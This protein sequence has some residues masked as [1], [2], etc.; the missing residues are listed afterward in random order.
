MTTPTPVP[1]IKIPSSGPKIN[2]YIKNLT[3]YTNNELKNKKKSIEDVLEIENRLNKF[4]DTY[5]K[6]YIEY[7]KIIAIFIFTIICIWLC[8]MINN[9]GILPEGFI[10]FIIIIISTIGIS[11]IYYV[12][13]NISIHNLLIYDQIDYE[14][15]ELKDEKSLETPQPTAST[16]KS[17]PTKCPVVCPANYVYNG[18]FCEYSLLQNLK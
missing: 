14:S 7:I 5:N 1:T 9:Q 11:W 16:Q 15:P 2:N 6:R 13:Q 12:Y 8:I 17:D 10:S 4:N 3:N 18:S